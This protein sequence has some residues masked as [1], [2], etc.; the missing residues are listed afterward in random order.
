[1]AKRFV[2]EAYCKMIGTPYCSSDAAQ[3]AAAAA[4]AAPAGAGASQHANRPA[5]AAA[6]APA[7]KRSRTGG[8]GAS[9][10]LPL[11][12]DD[13]FDEG[14]GA[15][16]GGA[17]NTAIRCLCGS[18]AERGAM[19]QCDAPQCHVWQHA[20]CVAATAA[21]AAAAAKGGRPQHY[22]ERCRVARAD[23]FWEV[24]DANIF[25]AMRVTSTGRMVQLGSNSV[26]VSGAALMIGL[27]GLAACVFG[28]AAAPVSL[29]QQN[30]SDRPDQT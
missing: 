6:A 18:G 22:C 1:M 2:E 30:Q 17:A 15:G 28:R 26:P 11:L 9:D 19:V 23:P 10:L 5:A 8:S 16:G 14:G 29:R 25:Q 20:D 7:A 13:L 27:G 3:P 12:F 21:A 4:A 24:F